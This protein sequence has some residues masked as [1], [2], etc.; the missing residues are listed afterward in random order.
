MV[1]LAAL[2]AVIAGSLL[3]P[4]LLAAPKKDKSADD[5]TI[6]VTFHWDDT[7]SAA[8]AIDDAGPVHFGD[9]GLL[10]E[11]ALGTIHIDLQEKETFALTGRTGAYEGLTGTGKYRIKTVKGRWFGETVYWKVWTFKGT[12]S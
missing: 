10:L 6:T 3:A 2:V 12:V 11:G 4:E 9:G 8:G 1:G 5:F 7:F